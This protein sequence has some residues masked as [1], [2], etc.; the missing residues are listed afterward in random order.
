MRFGAFVNA[1]SSEVIEACRL[2]S[3]C[4][5]GDLFGATYEDFG[6][7]N[8]NIWPGHNPN[9]DIRGPGNVVDIK[10]CGRLVVVTRRHLEK[11]VLKDRCIK[12]GESS[13]KKSCID[14]FDWREINAP[15]AQGRV[16]EVI[17]DGYHYLRKKGG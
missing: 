6:E 12:H 9:I 10:T 13:Y 15:T 4:I 11:V 7:T 3:A 1:Y 8:E 2:T 14:A 17:E 5:L 16:D